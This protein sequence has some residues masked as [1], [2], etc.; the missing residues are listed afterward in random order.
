MHLSISFS[1]SLLKVVWGGLLSLATEGVPI[2]TTPLR[3]M[4]RVK[5]NCIK[6][7]ATLPVLQ[8]WLLLWAWLL[9]GSRHEHIILFLILNPFGNHK[10]W[11]AHK[12]WPHA[13]GLRR[14]SST[15]LH[16]VAVPFAALEGH[17]VKQL[18]AKLY[19][20]CHGDIVGCSLKGPPRKKH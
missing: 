4:I 3:V 15:R 7:P 20:T 17:H 16:T 19:C 13:F 9:R 18:L 1:L 2:T 8:S 10:I 5:Q 14:I 11:W 6:M 12:L